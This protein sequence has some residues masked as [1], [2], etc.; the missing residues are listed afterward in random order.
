MSVVNI[1]HGSNAVHMFTDAG[2]FAADGSV[3][4]LLHK[5][6]PVPHLGAVFSSRGSYW[7]MQKIVTAISHHFSTFDEMIAGVRALFVSQYERHAE[8]I[9]AADAGEFELWICGWSS[10]RARP[11]SYGISSRNLQL[12]V[13]GVEAPAWALQQVG[14]MVL[15]R[16]GRFRQRL[17]AHPTNS[18]E[19]LG[20]AIAECQRQLR[21]FT[22]SGVEVTGI[23]GFIQ[24]TTVTSDGITTKILR[25]WPD[26]VGQ[27]VSPSPEIF[28]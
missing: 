26:Q 3:T 19:E 21:G 5:A 25:R 18:I 17:A 11:E 2:L 9:A 12:A 24:A 7:F 22:P 4:A 10:A 8:A 16:D 6:H 1:V 23:A 15:P 14:D 20:I 13:H 27:F 28:A